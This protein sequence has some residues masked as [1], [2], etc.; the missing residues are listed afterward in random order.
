MKQSEVDLN[1]NSIKNKL[2]FVG[3]KEKADT[4]ANVLK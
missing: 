3:W 1:L 2:N 4:M